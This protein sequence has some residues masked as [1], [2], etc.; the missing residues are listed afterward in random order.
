MIFLNK[1]LPFA[2]IIV[3][4]VACKKEDNLKRTYFDN[5]KKELKEEF[6]IAK[7]DTGIVR[8]GVYKS[9]FESKSES[10]VLFELSN[11]K[12]GVLHGKRTI[13]YKNGKPEIEENYNLGNLEGEWKNYFEN[14]DVKQIGF[15]T[16]NVTSG[17]WTLFYNENHKQKKEEISF[18]NNTENGPFKEYHL[19]GKLSATGIN[20]DGEP[21]SILVEFDT[22]GVKI[23]EILYKNGRVVHRKEGKELS[24]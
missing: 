19:N 2:L 22:I 20:R 3:F 13:Y 14:G 15:Y 4:I 16:N 8:N 5:D 12:D 9:Y 24:N 21:D 1:I 17:V 23:A 6:A 18:A 10:P 7:S 11:Y